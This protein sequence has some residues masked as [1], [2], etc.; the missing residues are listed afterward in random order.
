MR[1]HL[2]ISLYLFLSRGERF[3]E[4]ARFPL[5]FHWPELCHSPA[6]SHSM[7]KGMRLSQL[8]RY[9]NQDLL[10]APSSSERMAVQ[11]KADS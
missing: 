8:A 5:V 3:P 11:R 1:Q 4:I 2:V 6:L 10:P 7:E 9:V